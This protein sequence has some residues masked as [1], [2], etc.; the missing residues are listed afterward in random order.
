MTHALDD[1]SIR[2]IA[3]IQAAFDRTIGAL[4]RRA[5]LLGRLS[6]EQDRNEGWT[7]RFGRYL[8]RTEMII[9]VASSAL[10]LS[11]QVT[12]MLDIEQDPQLPT[13]VT[14]VQVPPST[15]NGAVP[16]M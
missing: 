5:D 7:R 3:A 15:D 11:E 13:V 12:A 16:S 10:Q 14:V 6:D 1:Y 8:I 9:A 2:G 4:R